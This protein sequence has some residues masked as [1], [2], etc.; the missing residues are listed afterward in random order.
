M[1]GL[2]LDVMLAFWQP[3]A[4]S[5]LGLMAIAQTLIIAGAN[6]VLVGSLASL[7]EGD[8]GPV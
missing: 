2:G 4:V 3:A 6:I 1:I 7:L 8:S 5:A